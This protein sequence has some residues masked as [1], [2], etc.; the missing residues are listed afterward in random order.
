MAWEFDGKLTINENEVKNHFNLKYLPIAK[1]L[2]DQDTYKFSMGQF[3]LHQFPSAI[4]EWEF[5]ARNIK[6]TNN[7]LKKFTKEDVDE[8]N[9]QIEAYCAL[10]F[11]KEELQWL[12]SK[13][14]WLH[15]DFADFL[16]DWKP[17]LKDF[18]ISY[19]ENLETGIHATFD[20]RHHRNSYYEIP[21]LYIIS[22]V[23]YRNHFNYEELFE[24]FKIETKKKIQLLKNKTFDIGIFSEFGTRRRLSFEAQEWLIQE[25]LDNNIQCFIG[26]SNMYL[27]KKYNIT[28]VGTMAHELF[29]L[30]GQG[31]LYHNPAF[32]NWYTLDLWVKEYG[33]E[34]GIAL[35]DTIG[36]DV[37]LRDFQ[38]TFATLFK[39]VRHDSG[40]PIEWGKKMIKHYKD[41][42]INPKEKTLLFSD[43][44][45]FQKATDI[46]HSFEKEINVAFGIGT[47]LTGPQVL[48]SLNIVCKPVMINGLHVAKLSDAEG[49]NMSRSPEAIQR[50]KNEIA[51]RLKTGK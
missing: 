5:K 44:L 19:D 22:E 23:Y 4:S 16:E 12:T 36:T 26:T 48:P 41:L 10:R 15:Y 8:I 25:L 43:S 49:K 38:K 7:I 39:G 2:L 14:H 20:G 32:T 3:F 24:E 34:N 13:H 27:A 46:K 9:K 28:A 33:I 42:G 37:F 35:T 51:W 11:E 29:L 1:S 30:V 18:Y 17:R 50:L 40:D 6:Q 31:L 47:Y 21:L 45:G